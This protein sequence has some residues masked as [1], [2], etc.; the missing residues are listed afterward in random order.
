MQCYLHVHVD[1]GPLLHQDEIN[2]AVLHKQEYSVTLSLRVNGWGSAVGRDVSIT[3][4]C[5][6]RIF[7]LNTP[8]IGKLNARNVRSK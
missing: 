8:Q 1:G 6:T 2:M 4:G 5:I 7:L 3:G